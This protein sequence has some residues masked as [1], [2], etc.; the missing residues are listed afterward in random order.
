MSFMCFFPRFASLA[1]TWSALRHRDIY[2]QWSER[3]SLWM[4]VI[5]QWS[6]TQY[7]PTNP[8]ITPTYKRHGF[9][10]YYLYKFNNRIGKMVT[11]VGFWVENEFQ[12]KGKNEFLEKDKILK[13]FWE[14]TQ[15]K[16]PT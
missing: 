2:G 6:E 4:A 1:W 11:M 14:T 10:Y 8:N 3:W 5:G 15:L 12:E 9:I 13:R 16:N 7:K